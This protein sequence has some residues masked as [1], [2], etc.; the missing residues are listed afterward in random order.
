[1]KLI[2]ADYIASLKEDRELD[3]LIEETLRENGF[4]ILFGP[5]KGVRQYGVDICAIGKDPDDNKKKLFLITVKQ[6]N[7][8][9][10]N[11]QGG[12]QALEPSL[13]EI[14]SVYIR[15]NISPAHK[16]LPIVIVIAH[17]GINEAAIQQ[18][19]AGFQKDFPKYSFDIWQLETIVSMVYD[20]ML[21]EK[22]FSESAR[23]LL[24]KVIVNLYNPEYDLS[25]YSLLIDD[26]LASNSKIKSTSAKENLKIFHKIKLILAI[27]FNYCKREEDSMLAIKAGELTILKVWDRYWESGILSDP[28]LMEVFIGL[29]FQKNQ[30][31]Q[32]YLSRLLPVCEIEDGFGKYCSNPVT[33]NSVVYSHF[34]QI[35]LCGLESV[36]LQALFGKDSPEL[37][38]ILESYSKAAVNGLLRIFENNEIITGPDTDDRMIEINLAFTLLYLF[39]RGEDIQKMIEDYLESMAEAI[40]L[41]K[42]FPEY[43][44]SLEK[45]AEFRA[46]PELREADASNSSSLLS[47]LMEWIAVLDAPSLYAR[48]LIYLNSVFKDVNLMLWFPEKETESVMFRRRAV[49]ETGYTLTELSFP[50]DYQKFKDGVFSDFLYNSQE[51]SFGYFRTGFWPIGLISCLHYR[52]YVS[53]YYWRRF[54][55]NFSELQS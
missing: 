7:L 39:G 16:R 34:G 9:R 10:K 13:R 38:D 30:I 17:N 46:T 19:W 40:V 54:I 21:N 43:G 14:I 53:P 27:V 45:V 36:T 2:L 24:R 49:P 18:N 12:N 50:D 35:A 25:D 23:E 4:E 31:N 11:W 1:M 33:Y 47:C 26:V 32:F 3:A 22:V 5:Q 41:M 29:L 44:N 20:S 42:T 6:G 37:G 52:T 51:C 8:D 28:S 15:N 55:K 48:A